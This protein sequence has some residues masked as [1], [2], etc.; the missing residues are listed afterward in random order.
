MTAGVSGAILVLA[1]TPGRATELRAAL[2]STSAGQNVLGALALDPLEQRTVEDARAALKAGFRDGSAP[3]KYYAV[4][5][6]GDVPISPRALADFRSASSVPEAFL[7]IGIADGAE[8]TAALGAAGVSWIAPIE[9]LAVQFPDRIGRAH[10]VAKED[11]AR[12]A[13]ELAASQSRV[14]YEIIKGQ[15]RTG[16]LPNGGVIMVHANKGGI[17]KS[18]IAAS[19]A[20]GL[21]RGSPVVLADMNTSGGWLQGTFAK[22]LEMRENGGFTDPDELLSYKGL[23]VLANRINHANERKIDPEQLASTLVRL[24]PHD[25]RPMELTLLPGIRSQRD[26][27]L[28]RADEPPTPARELLTKGQWAADLIDTLRTSVGGAGY[29]VLDTGDSEVSA[30]ATVMLTKSDLLVWIVDCSTERAMSDEYRHVSRMIQE[31]GGRLRG[32]LLIIANK[33]ADG[34]DRVET[35]EAPTLAQAQKLFEKLSSGGSPATVVGARWDR[36]ANAIADNVGLPVL[37]IADEHPDLRLI[38][39]LTAIV[40]AVNGSLT[41]I[42]SGGKKG[43]LLGGLFGKSR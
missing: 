7:V 1:A 12:A 29:V 40:N 17:G 31:F 37:A 43:G 23:S 13:A 3:L 19:L 42:V 41:M 24:I 8:Q 34:P 33:L 4:A 32:R 14:S 27:G 25:R 10:A 11:A 5:V 15:D 36:R 26:Y 22:W 30:S 21:S 35:P 39:D 18:M 9:D 6:F 28:G 2:E 38:G 16:I 20:Y